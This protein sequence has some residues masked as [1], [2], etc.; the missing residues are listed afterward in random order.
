MD[1]TQIIVVH[2]FH[3]HYSSPLLKNS[4]LKA[5]NKSYAIELLILL[6]KQSKQLGV[7]KK[8]DFAMNRVIKSW[9]SRI[10]SKTS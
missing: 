5:K 4:F 9:D 3:H 8:I 1:V 6:P 7:L 2:N 10:D